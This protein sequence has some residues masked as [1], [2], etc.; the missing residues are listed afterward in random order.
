MKPYVVVAIPALFVLLASALFSGCRF[1]AGASSS[2]P[3]LPNPPSSPSYSL[4]VL[5]LND[6]SSMGS[7]SSE[8]YAIK[9]GSVGGEYVGHRL[10]SESFS[11]RGGGYEGM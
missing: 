1:G 9:N 8:N 10:S 3:A 4:K 7:A 6:S 11:V 5:P 2:R